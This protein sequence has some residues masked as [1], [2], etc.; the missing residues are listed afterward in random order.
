MYNVHLVWHIISL[1]ECAMVVNHFHSSF[2]MLVIRSKKTKKWWS[3]AN[4]RPLQPFEWV[5]YGIVGDGRRVPQRENTNK[6]QWEWQKTCGWLATNW[7]SD[8]STHFLLLTRK[9]HI[10][11]FVSRSPQYNIGLFFIATYM[12]DHFNT[13]TTSSLASQSQ[14]LCC[15]KFRFNQIKG[16]RPSTTCDEAVFVP[17]L[18]PHPSRQ[19]R[20]PRLFWCSKRKPSEFRV[21]RSCKKDDAKSVLSFPYYQKYNF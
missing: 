19:R 14:V 10:H 17:F 9:K 15:S 4:S 18:P 20:K 7:F 16:D 2:L 21:K 8:R 3:I 13:L 5:R 12:K 1:W 11:A 6:K